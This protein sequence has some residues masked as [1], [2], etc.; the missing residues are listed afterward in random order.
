MLKAKIFSTTTMNA[1]TSTHTQNKINKI[2]ASL[3]LKKIYYFVFFFFFLP[4]FVNYCILMYLET[5][6]L[7]IYNFLVL[8]EFLFGAFF[9]FFFLYT[10][11]S[12]SLKS[13][14]RP[15]HNP[16]CKQ[17]TIHCTSMKQPLPLERKREAEWE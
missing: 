15:W 2:L 7:C 12:P 14:I 10:L 13:W 9:F 4:L 3:V 5:T 1:L 16:M 8:Y 17:T 6:I 11:A